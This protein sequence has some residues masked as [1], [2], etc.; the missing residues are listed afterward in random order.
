ML[1]K[2][3]KKVRLGLKMRDVKVKKTQN[4]VPTD[5]SLLITFNYLGNRFSILLWILRQEIGIL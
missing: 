4:K 3:E 1:E 2:E 5:F